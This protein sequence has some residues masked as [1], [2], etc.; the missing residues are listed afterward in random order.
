MCHILG[1]LTISTYLYTCGIFRNYVWWL[2]LKEKELWI[3]DWDWEHFLRR[4]PSNF[5][6]KLGSEICFEKKTITFNFGAPTKYQLKNHSAIHWLFQ[7]NYQF[8]TPSYDSIEK[9]ILPEASPITTPSSNW[10]T[11]PPSPTTWFLGP[12]DS[13]THSRP[14]NCH[15][16]VFFLG[17]IWVFS[18]KK[19][20]TL[21]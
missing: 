18:K 3:D 1:G 11:S 12:S 14:A 7:Q 17:F 6:P 8:W 4:C 15:A 19:S 9:K 5:N 20:R 10:H 13:L 16:L 2:K 21:F